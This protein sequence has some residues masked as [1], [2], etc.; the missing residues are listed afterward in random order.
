MR[1][2]LA[3]RRM[4]AHCVFVIGS[5]CV[6]VYSYSIADGGW[7]VRWGGPGRLGR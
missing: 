6:V 4:W 7:A 2:S 5:G 1:R 3:Q